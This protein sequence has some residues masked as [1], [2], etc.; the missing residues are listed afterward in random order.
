M[1]FSLTTIGLGSFL[2]LGPTCPWL[3][4]ASP[5]GDAKERSAVFA[6]HVRSDSCLLLPNASKSPPVGVNRSKIVPALPASCT[7]AL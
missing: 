3:L 2:E 1:I 4:E 5:R 7:D 6:S